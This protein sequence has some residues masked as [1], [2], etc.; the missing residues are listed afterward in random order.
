MKSKEQVKTI[1]SQK[2]NKNL[3]VDSYEQDLKDLD[4]AF[5]RVYEQ[6][7]RAIKYLENN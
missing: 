6:I 1:L 2:Q 4:Y 7:E 5:P 3:I